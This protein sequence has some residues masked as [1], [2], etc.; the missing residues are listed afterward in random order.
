MERE[1]KGKSSWND[2]RPPREVKRKPA[3][4]AANDD[5]LA[6]KATQP[7]H[8]HD[9]NVSRRAALDWSCVPSS[10]F[11][12]QDQLELALFLVNAKKEHRHEILDKAVFH[13]LKSFLL[14]TLNQEVDLK[15]EGC[16]SSSAHSIRQGGGHHHMKTGLDPN[17]NHEHLSAGACK[18]IHDMIMRDFKNVTDH[19]SRQHK[20]FDKS[21]IEKELNNASFGTL[22]DALRRS[23]RSEHQREEPSDSET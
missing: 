4:A 2:Q 17:T 1:R 16:S 6:K 7:S 23:E 13:D 14:W 19:A 18:L 5:R 11:Q 21:F 10:T 20:A 12:A 9:K 15:D 22:V 3:P 8:Q